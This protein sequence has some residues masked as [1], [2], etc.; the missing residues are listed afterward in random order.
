MVEPAA[1]GEEVVDGL[2]RGVLQRGRVAVA[3]VAVVE[4]PVGSR[5][6]GEPAESVVLIVRRASAV[7]HLRA[8]AQLV[9]LIGDRR[10]AGRRD[11]GEARDPVIGVGDR[12]AVGAG[13]AQRL[14]RAVEDEAR[15]ERC[16]RVGM[17]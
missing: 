7:D 17:G 8:M 2:G 16:L 1:R 3:V 11:G 9:V 6:L 5:R 10:E 12:D 15:G 14:T 13:A 4:R